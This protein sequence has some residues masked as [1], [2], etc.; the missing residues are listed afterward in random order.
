MNMKKVSL[1]MVLSMILLASCNSTGK[2]DKNLKEAHKEMG[3]GVNITFS[4]QLAGGFK[5]GPK[6]E[7]YMIGFSDED[8]EKVLADYIR[9]ATKKLL[10][11]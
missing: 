11:G 3:A 9:P 5:I 1:V 7:G 8:F 6:D 4:K 2:F 10:F